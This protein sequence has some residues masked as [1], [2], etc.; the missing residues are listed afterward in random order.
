MI[1]REYAFIGEET[2]PKTLTVTEAI[3]NFSEILG[4]VRFK[5][6]RFILLRGGK[7]VAELGPTDAAPLVRLEELPATLEGLPHLEPD[8]AARFAQ[9]L[10]SCAAATVPP[11]VPWA[12]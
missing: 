4:R 5:G 2:V 7:P 12:S 9:D 8:D 10:E 3:R 6:E 11:P 1:I